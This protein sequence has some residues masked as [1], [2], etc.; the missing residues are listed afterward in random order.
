MLIASLIIIP[1][2]VHIL[3]GLT[4]WST[5]RDIWDLDRISLLQDKNLKPSK[6]C[7][8]NSKLTVRIPDTL[9]GGS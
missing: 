9:S 3:L 5:T 8:S 7:S 4:L 6:V 2:I 1:A